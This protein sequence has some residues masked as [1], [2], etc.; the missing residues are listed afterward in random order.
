MSAPFEPQPGCWHGRA[1]GGRIV[2]KQ[3]R[4]GNPRRW[5]GRLLLVATVALGACSDRTPSAPPLTGMVVIDD[6]VNHLSGHIGETSGTPETAVLLR[7]VQP[8]KGRG[9]RMALLAPSGARIGYDVRIPAGGILRVGTALVLDRVAP[10][11]VAGVRYT[12]S[13]D[14]HVIYTRDEQPRPG[15]RHVHW[16]DEEI[17]VAPWQGRSVRLT[18]TTTRLGQGP[19][20]GV[21]AWSRVQLLQRSERPR[22]PARADAPNV[23]LV[24]VD[25]LRA[26]HVGAY[27]GGPDITPNL[28][29]WAARGTLFEEAF[30]QA[31]WTLP[32]MATI[33]TGLYPRGHGVVGRSEQWGVPAGAT[34]GGSWAYLSDGLPTLAATA[35]GA[36][37]STFGVTSNLLISR[38]NNLARGFERFD[39]LPVS[40]MPIQWARAPEVNAIF[41]DWL[42][43]NHEWRFF[44]YLHYM[45]PHDPYVPHE[46]ARE[47]APADMRPDVRDGVIRHLARRVETGHQTVP[48]AW[49]SYLRGLYAGEVRAWDRGFAGLL[50][51]LEATGVS[52]RTVIVFTA[53]HGEEFLEHGQLGHRKQVFAES[54][55]VPLVV[56]GPRIPAGRRPGL[57]ELVDLYPTI[58][59]LLG[60]PAP[61]SLPGRDLLAADEASAAAFSDTRYGT[62]VGAGDVELVAMRT[63]RDTIV[64][65]P[66]AGTARRYGRTS[67]PGERSPM[68]HDPGTAALVE[69]ARAWRSAIHPPPT[70]P[71]GV[72]VRIDD[73]LRALGYVE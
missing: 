66:E 2:E 69:R 48:A 73:R 50:S 53:D 31:P 58:A 1:R 36:G 61:E 29:A 15:R 46:G 21:P 34:D 37:I 4:E 19:L 32:S 72:A 49:L 11:D 8:A 67:D 17:D 47:A 7:S 28:D 35:R 9:Q 43:T 5:C 70:L 51:L 22:Q 10:D 3:R 71:G 44:A 52:E 55:H 56:V 24:V 14:D 20:P 16:R 26:D 38:E 63:A 64:W 57:V 39:E 41:R 27:G 12:V 18:L 65:E 59:G 54:V 68:G 6:V 42:Q 30:A 23:I 45:E 33:F 13:L 60:L 40:P 25:T 62:G